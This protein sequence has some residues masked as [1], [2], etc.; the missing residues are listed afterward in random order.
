MTNSF[1]CNSLTFIS[2]GTQGH[3]RWS[4]CSAASLLTRT[5]QEPMPLWSANLINVNGKN[6]VWS[7][8]SISP[9][10]HV[11]KVRVKPVVPQHRDVQER[12]DVSSNSIYSPHSWTPGLHPWS[13]SWRWRSWVVSS[14]GNWGSFLI[15]A[16]LPLPKLHSDWLLRWS[17]LDDDAQM[18]LVW[19]AWQ[20]KQHLFSNVC[21]LAACT[22]PLGVI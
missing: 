16:H 17:A 14:S 4:V 5:R 2:D 7:D 10:R 9:F 13:R 22:S 21:W 20:E 15:R 12:R 19:E 3:E 6:I 18:N 11:M 8:P 1:C